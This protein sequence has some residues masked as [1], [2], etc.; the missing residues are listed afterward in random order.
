MVYLIKKWPE[1]LGIADDKTGNLPLHFALQYAPRGLDVDTRM[2]EKVLAYRAAACYVVNKAGFY[3]IH[4]ATRSACPL[5]IMETLLKISPYSYA[6][7]TEN[8][9]RL[10]PIDMAI[11]S[12]AA[13]D[14]IGLMLGYA[15][16]S[17]SIRTKRI[18][19]D[20]QH[21]S[22]GELAGEMTKKDCFYD[23]TIEDKLKRHSLENVESAT[24]VSSELQE[25]ESMISLTDAH[26]SLQQKYKD[27][28]EEMRK[29]RLKMHS[30]VTDL[31]SRNDEIR[32]LKKDVS[33]GKDRIQILD[34][35][36]KVLNE[37]LKRLGS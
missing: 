21:P 13:G 12:G 10:L 23:K 14:V 2:I 32:G 9:L 7:Y 16:V 28:G 6:F 20:R 11:A 37:K 26:T 17:D 8:Y 4:L 34:R 27:Q 5:H 31:K 15:E 1:S 25:Y 35:E 22:R 19:E 3:P 33:W 29:M 24:D 18:M 30:L 36:V